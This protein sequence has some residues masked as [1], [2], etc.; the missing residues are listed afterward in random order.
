MDQEARAEVVA[1]DGCRLRARLAGR[2]DA[3]ALLL[4]HPIGFSGAFWDPVADLLAPHFSLLIP[5]A[6]GHGGSA[7]GA[8]ETSIE[9]LADDLLAIMEGRG[10]GAATV[11]GCSL[12]SAT[13]MHFGAAH[14]ERTTG[15]VLANAPARIPLPRERFDAMI[16]AAR[17]GGYAE[18]ARGMLTRWLA[19]GAAAAR[20]DWFADQEAAITRT[21]GDGFADA[22]AALRDSDRGDDL[23][24]I[25]LPLLVVTG[26]Y[27][28][29]FDPAAAA[30]MAR[31]V[32]DGECS[33]IGCAG[34]LA[35]LE[36][37]DEFAARVHEFHDRRL[38]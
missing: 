1:S 6:R 30:A 5:D 25:H 20:P 10:V 38:G 23:A 13:A 3:P 24:R 18:L 21:D 22:F 12:G 9:Q 15:L 2:V 14:A 36:Q 37:P 11:I 27:D 31:G 26:E 16:A 4:V 19:P 17:S 28:Q 8:G 7:R 32:S 34:H 29:A 33:V 35:P